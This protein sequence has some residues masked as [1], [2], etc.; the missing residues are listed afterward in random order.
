VTLFATVLIGLTSLDAGGRLLPS[1]VRARLGIAPPVTSDADILHFPPSERGELIRTGD[2]AQYGN[3]PAR[4]AQERPIDFET[5]ARGYRN[6]G[7][8]LEDADVVV[9]GD[10]FAEG[11]SLSQGDTLPSQLARRTGLRVYNHA[12]RGPPPFA[13]PRAYAASD[14]LRE[15]PPRVVVWDIVDRL[16]QP[17]PR[18]GTTPPRPPGL[19]AR[20]QPFIDSSPAVLLAQSAMRALA[21]SMPDHL[22][23]N[24][25][26]IAR[27]P[28]GGSMLFLSEELEAAR[29]P[30]EGKAAAMAAGIVDVRDAIAARGAPLVMLLVPNKWDVYGDLVRDV[31]PADGPAPP[32][33]RAQIDLMEEHLVRAGMTVVNLRRRFQVEAARR[34][35]AGEP[36]IYWLD[37]THWNP[38]GVAIAADELG[39]ALERLGIRR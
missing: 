20:A 31:F 24:G 19:K 5:D 17:E 9:I 4:Y 22:P 28:S 27:L 37:D 39:A 6:R 8:R 29:R 11:E 35:A 26:R 10:S 15:H 25:V 12:Y 14:D 38:A 23:E 33:A 13:L 7:V 21:R 36:P 16:V 30:Q 3:L 1:L 2:V 34:E 18:P 32:P